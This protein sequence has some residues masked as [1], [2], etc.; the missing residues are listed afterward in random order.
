MPI[1]RQKFLAAVTAMARLQMESASIRAELE[2]VGR[3]RSNALLRIAEDRDEMSALRNSPGHRGS[4]VTKLQCDIDG[5]GIERRIAENEA[6]VAVLTTRYAELG[7]RVTAAI[8]RAHSAG[9]LLD[10]LREELD[11]AEA[12]ELRVKMRAASS[13]SNPPRAQ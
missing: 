11:E 13:A 6:V 4:L 7:Q 12:A 8:R 9:Q 5:L 1:D 2:E 3:M 10:R